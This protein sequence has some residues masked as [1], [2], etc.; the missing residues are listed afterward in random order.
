MGVT[1]RLPPGLTL[2]IL[3]NYYNADK[4][5]KRMPTN[6]QHNRNLYAAEFRR[7]RNIIY[8]SG[9]PLN[10]FYSTYRRYSNLRNANLNRTVRRAAGKFKAGRS[11]AAVRPALLRNLSEFGRNY[12]NM[13]RSIAYRNASPIKR[14]R[15]SRSSP[16]R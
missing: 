13:L 15:T 3:R 16:R 8:A 12:G 11:V 4:R 1:M 7:M 2:N 14:R 5:L 10:P 9:V 6:T